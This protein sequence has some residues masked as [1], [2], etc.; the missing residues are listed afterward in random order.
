MNY[1]LYISAAGALSNLHRQDV[2]T[3]NLV[4]IET[5]GFKPDV[6]VFRQRLPQRVAS[7]APIEPQLLLER[8]GGS[9]TLNPTHLNLTQGNLIDTGDDLDLAIDGEG[10]FVVKSADGQMRLT[11]DGRFAM[12]A[13][14]T[15]VTAGSGLQVLDPQNRA[16]RLNREGR[17]EIDANGDVR[18]N[19][20]IAATI[21]VAMPQD[22]SALV[23]VG[24]NLLRDPNLAG[25]TASN[26]KARLVQGY[27]E[28]SGVNAIS[29]LRDLVGAAKSIQANIKMMQYQDHI[30]GQAINTMGRVA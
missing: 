18:Q 25:N 17:V 5:I 20:S 26:D 10:F 8:L 9:P 21:R 16:I 22:P 29:T 13:R 28:S 24:G 4:N 2:I 15:L 6:V 7:G 27:L 19:G 12:D 11:R 30:M 14:G 1:G 3:N 23:K